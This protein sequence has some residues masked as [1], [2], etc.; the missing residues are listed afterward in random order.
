MKH[1]QRDPLGVQEQDLN[2]DKSS[3]SWKN[4]QDREYKNQSINT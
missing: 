2:Q 4:A 3:I 1:G